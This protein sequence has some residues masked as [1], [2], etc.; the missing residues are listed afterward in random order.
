M[1]CTF[2]FTPTLFNV[3]VSVANRT[4]HVQPHSTAVDD[5]EPR[6]Q[7]H[8]WAPRQLQAAAQTS[9]TLYVSTIGEAMGTNIRRHL[10]NASTSFVE[11]RDDALP[12]IEDSVQAALDDIL[13]G[14]GGFALT[15]SGNYSAVDVTYEVS[16]IRI[17]TRGFAGAILVVNA[18]GLVVVFALTTWTRLFSRSPA[19]DFADLG[20]M[21]AGTALGKAGV[22]HVGAAG[23]ETGAGG[24]EWGPGR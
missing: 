10:N 11:P 7:M 3:Y 16:A 15:Q 19:F 20:G 17:G 23:H 21:V 18:V 14:F 9:T 8:E 2:Y 22:T 5:P 12:A 24:M 6:G 13:V 4:I 1:Q